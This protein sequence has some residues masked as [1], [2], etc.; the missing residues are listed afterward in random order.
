MKAL[1]WKE[2]RENLKWALI[3]CVLLSLALCYSWSMVID[4]GKNSY[5]SICSPLIQTSLLFGSFITATA[6]GFLQ[7]FP[8]QIRDR[9]AFLV[10]R[11]VS[12]K[13]LFWAKASAGLALYFTAMG[14]PYLVLCLGAAIPGAIHGPFYWGMTLPGL[15]SIIVGSS[16]Y[17]LAVLCAMRSAAW[18]GSKLLPLL[19]GVGILILSQVVGSAS[20]AFLAAG[21]FL[22]LATLAS[23]SAFISSS[24]PVSRRLRTLP[25]ALLLFL[26]YTILFFFTVSLVIVLS[27][28]SLN[29]V[30]ENYRLMKDGAIVLVRADKTGTQVS[31]LDGTALP[32]TPRDLEQFYSKTL[33]EKGMTYRDIEGIR[34]EYNDFHN[35]T[36]WF[37]PELGTE[38][39]RWFYLDDKGYFVRYSMDQNLIDG[40][41]GTTGFS[42][43]A[44][45]PKDRFAGKFHKGKYT[46][47]QTY[48]FGSGAYWIDLLNQQVIALKHNGWDSEVL[49][50]ATLSS[51]SRESIENQMAVLLTSPGRTL[52]FY[53]SDG[54]LLFQT[55]LAQDET[56]YPTIVLMKLEDNSRYY[57][58][59]DP[60]RPM[61][62]Q[63]PGKVLA[64]DSKGNSA[65]TWDL[66]PLKKQ[67]YGTSWESFFYV[68]SIGPGLYGTY[69]CTI[70]IGVLNGSKT[71]QTEWNNLSA[72]NNVFYILT[73]GITGI[74]LVSAF[75]G[76][77]RMRRYSFSRREQAWW[78]LFTFLGGLPAF[79]AFLSVHTWP[80][81]LPCP[82][83]RKTRPLNSNQCPHCQEEW[84]EKKLD[85]TEIFSVPPH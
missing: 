16:F 2:I 25:L 29:Y 11:P 40:Y 12:L 59:L 8:E 44:P 22:L 46:Q 60:N 77:R 21:L 32:L 80:A 81:Q 76:W 38:R 39:G 28:R 18:K 69:L 43:A 55:Q 53:K 58:K 5:L 3:A 67:T 13:T 82:A 71:Y 65:G 79:F 42:D 45:A 48:L 19:A 24:A 34:S 66:P 52:E 35:A 85:G 1:F 20:I 6:L 14:L 61:K 41:L 54:S 47:D 26:G 33:D 84:P 23:I 49:A 73:A 62:E 17:F 30:Q 37:K 63:L 56:D 7:I 27:P 51:S 70:Y 9:W 83:C 68:P 72:K 75:C 50:A 36:H 78:T 10:H 74:G 64:Y 31:R 15:L 4:S 57:V